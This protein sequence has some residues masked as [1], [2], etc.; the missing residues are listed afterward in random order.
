MI[1]VSLS[2]PRY[3]VNRLYSW[4]KKH[5]LQSSAEGGGGAIEIFRRRRSS[6][7]R[8]VRKP[9]TIPPIASIISRETGFGFVVTLLEEGR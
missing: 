5:F 8:K 4:K 3:L 2:L 6:A 7:S 9:N 1:A